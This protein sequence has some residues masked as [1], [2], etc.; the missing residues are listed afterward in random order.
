MKIALKR[1]FQNA[2]KPIPT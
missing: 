2:L 1:W